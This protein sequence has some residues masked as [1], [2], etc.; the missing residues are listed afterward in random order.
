MLESKAQCWL[1]SMQTM[2]PHGDYSSFNFPF[3]WD[4]PQIEAGCN[5]PIGLL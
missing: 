4:I 5:S 1:E 3:Y 2:I